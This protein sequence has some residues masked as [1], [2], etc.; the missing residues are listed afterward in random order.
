VS[1]GL[2]NLEEFEDLVFALIC[3]TVG[4][5]KVD[6]GTYFYFLLVTFGGG[7]RTSRHD[8]EFLTRRCCFL[9]HRCRVE[10]GGA[11]KYIL[12]DLIEDVVVRCD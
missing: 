8:G 10:K 2:G 11:V 9:A 12:G 4:I 3:K 6:Y 1:C 5:A 7:E